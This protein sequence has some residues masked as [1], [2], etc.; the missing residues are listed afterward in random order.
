MNQENKAKIII[1]STYVGL[2]LV[3]ALIII[4]SH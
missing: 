4:F 3:A 2:M 1:L